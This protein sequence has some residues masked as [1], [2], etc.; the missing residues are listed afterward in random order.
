MGKF[1]LDD[2]SVNYP[3][4]GYQCA[5]CEHLRHE[6]PKDGIGS[7]CDAFPER[8]PREILGGEHDHTQPFPGDNGI[9]FEVRK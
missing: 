8:I 5:R 2:R 9:R 1:I 3:I 4:Y 7:V 6:L